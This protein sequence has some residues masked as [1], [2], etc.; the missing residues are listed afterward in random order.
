M[1][2]FYLNVS[3]PSRFREFCRNCLCVQ[4]F[5]IPIRL[6]PWEMCV[7]NTRCSILGGPINNR[8]LSWEAISFHSRICFLQKF[9]SRN[10]RQIGIEI[11]HYETWKFCILSLILFCF[12][13]VHCCLQVMCCPS[14]AVETI[15]IPAVS[16]K[17]VF[18]IKKLYRVD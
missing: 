6:L 10:S 16:L 17:S 14:L 5:R 12:G 1:R 7:P 11:W 3:I 9:Y 2:D 18:S 13:I 8:Y 4:I 15:T